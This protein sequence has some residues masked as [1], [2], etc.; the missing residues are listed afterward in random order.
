[1]KRKDERWYLRR[2]KCK[3]QHAKKETNE[4][5]TLKSISHREHSPGACRSRRKTRVNIFY[6]FIT[7]TPAHPALFP[8]SR[9]F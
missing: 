4:G 2:K 7:V 1:M 8:S 5:L 6:R 3:K 9:L